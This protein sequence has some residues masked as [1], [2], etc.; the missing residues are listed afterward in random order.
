MGKVVF[1][2]FHL[3]LKFREALVQVINETFACSTVPMKVGEF[4]KEDKEN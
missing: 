4:L 1:P 3:I 2:F